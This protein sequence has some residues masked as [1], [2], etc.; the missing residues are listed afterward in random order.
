MR[1]SVTC[2]NCNKPSWKGCGAQ[3]EQVLGD[4]QRGQRCRRH[5]VPTP[6]AKHRSWFSR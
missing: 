2:K 1:R 6:I 3:I 5:H 4:V